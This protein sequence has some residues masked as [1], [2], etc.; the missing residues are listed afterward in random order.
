MIAGD[1]D[2][3]HA[4]WERSVRATHSFLLEEDIAFFSPLV[5]EIF[6]LDLEF[7][8]VIEEERLLGFMALDTAVAPVKLEA[9][10][11]DPAYFRKGAGRALAEKAMEL[12]GPLVLDVNEQ[13]PGAREFYL[14]LRFTETGRSPLDGAGKPFPLIHMRCE[15]KQH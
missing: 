11:V 6:G 3:M 14:R 7:W 13:N 12:Y 15:A 10:F 4:V 1:Y 9:L 5:R 8:V 2:A